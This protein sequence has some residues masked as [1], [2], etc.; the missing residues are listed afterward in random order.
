M[1]QPASLGCAPAHRDATASRW[2]FALAALALATAAAALAGWAPLRF[3]IV[4]VFLFA[5][6]HNWLE[7]RYFLT[8]LPARWGRLRGFFLLAFAG[9]FTLAAA[10]AAL[11][12]S[13]YVVDLDAWVGR[14]AGLAAWNTVLVLWIATLAHLRS[15]QNP[16]REW[17]WIWPVAFA[18][19]GLTWL[20]TA[21]VWGSMALVYLHPLMAFWLLDREMKR[22]RPEWRPVFHVCL[23]CLPLVLG[24]L[25]WKLAAAPALPDGDQLS[26]DISNH[27]GAWV[28]PGVSSHLLVATHTFL[29]M[30]HYG[31]WVVAIPLIGLRS[32]PWKLQTVPLA[33]RSPTWRLAVYVFLGVGLAVV[34]ILWGC[35]LGDYT[36]TRD[37]YFTVALLHVL[38]EVPF[39]LRSL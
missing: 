18:L 24:L 29:E 17:G 5:G 2:A 37:V 9:I 34:V 20:P 8:R 4:T 6:P 21:A 1:N 38:A 22:S 7:F 11:R 16:R 26:Q 12:L 15:R 19:A 23:A 28:L 10:Y 35:F 36:R 13:S 33:R 3:S 14:D 25:W 32:A 30:L 31:V 39:L 27:A